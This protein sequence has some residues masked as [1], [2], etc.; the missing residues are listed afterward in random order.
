MTTSAQKVANS[1]LGSF[2]V[3][4]DT[5]AGIDYQLVKLVDGTEGSTSPFGTATHPIVTTSGASIPGWDYVSLSQA[6]TTDTYTFKTG[7]ASGTTV[8]TITITYTDSGK[9]TIST[10]VRT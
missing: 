1:P 3:A 8:G 2:S 6:S 7:G 5:I 9:S 10:V 4:T